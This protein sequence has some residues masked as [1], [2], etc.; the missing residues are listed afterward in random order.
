MAR[1]IDTGDHPRRKVGRMDLENTL[2][3]ILIAP[4]EAHAGFMSHPENEPPMNMADGLEEHNQWGTVHVNENLSEEDL[5][6][7]H[8]SAMAQYRD[9]GIDPY[10]RDVRL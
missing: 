5:Q 1:G 3:S 9:K 8:D 10:E 2:R 4:F 6:G 7:M